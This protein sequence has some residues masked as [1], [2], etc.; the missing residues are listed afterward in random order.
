MDAIVV[1]IIVQQTQHVIQG[2]WQNIFVLG[3]IERPP[4]QRNILVTTP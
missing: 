1:F 4:I 3:T 2:V